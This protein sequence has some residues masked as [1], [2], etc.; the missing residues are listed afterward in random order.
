MAGQAVDARA[1]SKIS[2]LLSFDVDILTRPDMD[3]VLYGQGCEAKSINKHSDPR[4]QVS[5]YGYKIH[6]VGEVRTTSMILRPG[7]EEKNWR[8]CR[9]VSVQK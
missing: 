5:M 9:D 1:S 4:I 2:S 7:S 6:E 8:K 3:L